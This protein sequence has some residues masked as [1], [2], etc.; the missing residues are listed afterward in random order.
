MLV[1][2]RYGIRLHANLINNDLEIVK[3]KVLVVGRY[4][5]RLHANLINNDLQIVIQKSAGCWPVWD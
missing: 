3:Q 1:V 5:I 4:G 2:G